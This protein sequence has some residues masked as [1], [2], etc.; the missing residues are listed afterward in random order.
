M[1]KQTF[2]QGLA[3]LAAAYAV[4]LSV[5]RAGVYWDQL[6]KFP[7]AAF[8]R[9]VKSVVSTDE[10][11]PMAAKLREVASAEARK[12]EGQ[13]IPYPATWLRA[14]GFED[15]DHVDVVPLP[16]TRGEKGRIA[17]SVAALQTLFGANDGKAD[18]PAGNGVPRRRVRG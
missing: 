10:R 17:S 13:F 8:L 1:E 18:L 14:R 7:D 15:E 5:E 16:H 12:D 11:F 4:E 6:Q 2:Q 9:A 3:Y